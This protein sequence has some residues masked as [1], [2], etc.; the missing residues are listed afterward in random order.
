MKISIVI[1]TYYRQ[2]DKSSEYLRRALDS[3]FN[4]THQDF[5]IYLIGDRY[6]KSE[7][8]EEIVSYMTM[9]SCILKIS[10]W[11]KKEIFTKTNMRC[12]L[13]VE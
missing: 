13:T 6:E 10:M 11:Q 1:A 5:K 3:I 8:I 9:K 12:G 4:Q 2:D 7:E